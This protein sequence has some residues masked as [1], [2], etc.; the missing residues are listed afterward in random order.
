MKVSQ[1]N[2]LDFISNHR[3]ISATINVKKDVP[4]ITRKKIINYKDVCPA[5]MMENFHPPLLGPNTNTNEAQ[6]QL[7]MQ[8][9]EMLDKCV[10]EKTIK[11]P[12]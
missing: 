6:T 1:L 5:T 10:P 11:R 12:K 8:L 2:M 3:L 4:M 7:I 9:H